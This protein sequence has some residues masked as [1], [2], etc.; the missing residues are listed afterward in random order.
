MKTVVIIDDEPLARMLVK[1]YLQNHTDIQVLQEC[2]DGFEGIKAI[3][4]LRPDFVFLDVQMPKLNGFEMLELIENPPMVIFTTAF[5]EY[6]LK[7]FEANA[8]DY[9]LKPFNKERF[10]KALKKCLEQNNSKE[11]LPVSTHAFEN[12]PD[13]ANR[14]VVKTNNNIKIIPVSEIIY[15][16]AYDDYVNLYS[17]EACYIKKKTMSFYENTLNKNEFIRIHRSYILN[18]AFLT[19]I[20]QINKDSYISVLKNGAK[21]ALSRA[22]YGLLK[23]KLNI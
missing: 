3:Q 10:D 15:I 20:E 6:A 5:D 17:G 7:A 14:I 9:L 23:E 19:R 13:S 22:G 21:L 4:T 12:Y 1:E 8:I 18:I 11:E 2:S 16:E